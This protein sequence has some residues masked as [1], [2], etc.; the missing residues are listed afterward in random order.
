[1]RSIFASAIWR[2][3]LLSAVFAWPFGLVAQ[4]FSA[5]YAL[6]RA[7]AATGAAIP[8]ALFDLGAVRVAPAVLADARFSGAGLSMEA[9]RNWFGQVGVGRSL[10]PHASLPGG[11]SVEDVLAVS[12]GYR[13]SDGE[14]VSLQLSRSRATERLGLSVSYDW[15]RYFVRFSYDQGLRLTPADVVRFSAGVRF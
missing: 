5:D 4:T 11:A 1:M 7:A 9:G 14:S 8:P 3:A 10:Q 12:G 2:A 13:W 6:T 15:P